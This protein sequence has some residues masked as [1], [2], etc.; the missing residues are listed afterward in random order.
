MSSQHCFDWRERLILSFLYKALERNAAQLI[1]IKTVEY[2]NASIKSTR[3]IQC[4]DILC[5]LV[6]SLLSFFY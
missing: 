4:E 2:N 6:I 1:L 3:P 5:M